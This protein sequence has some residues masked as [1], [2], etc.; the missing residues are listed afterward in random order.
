LKIWLLEFGLYNTL[1]KHKHYVSL[2]VLCTVTN[3]LTRSA[4]HA[5]AQNEKRVSTSPH[6]SP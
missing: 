6:L 5:T 3:Y 2:S 1:D 4:R